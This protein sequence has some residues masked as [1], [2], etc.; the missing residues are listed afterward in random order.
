MYIYKITNKLSGQCYIGQ[1]ANP[2]ERWYAHT[3]GQ[4]SPIQVAIKELGVQNFTFEIIEYCSQEEANERE[5]FWIGFYHSYGNGYNTNG[6]E[7]R[8]QKRK[9]TGVPP[10]QVKPRLG[11]NSKSP[12]E[13]LDPKT[14]E[15]LHS[16][17]SIAA[18]QQFCNCGNSG[19]ISAVCRGRGRTAYG[20][21]W[22]Y[23]ENLKNF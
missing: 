21:A 8:G 7:G 6:G 3:H 17:E 19:N 5:S 1:S 15:V 16:F 10:K 20:Y 4:S 18:A 23:A 22:R 11:D 13:A 14:G 12:V 9:P 2:F